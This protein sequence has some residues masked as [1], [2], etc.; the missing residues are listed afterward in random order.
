MRVA[1]DD[2]LASACHI[3]WTWDDQ[4][5]EIVKRQGSQMATSGGKP[6]DTVVKTSFFQHVH[7][8]GLWMRAQYPG[9]PV[10]GIVGMQIGV[11]EVG[12]LTLPATG[13]DAGHAS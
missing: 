5:V 2:Q 4:P 6:A 11:L 1:V 10:Y 3:L 7:L 12:R 8:T 13:R 9:T